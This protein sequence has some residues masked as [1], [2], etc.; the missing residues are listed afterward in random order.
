MRTSLSTGKGAWGGRVNIAG[1]QAGLRI[2][3]PSDVFSI[4][5]R[6]FESGVSS[7]ITM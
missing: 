6:V 3:G 4:P 2:V 1:I 5:S 7:V